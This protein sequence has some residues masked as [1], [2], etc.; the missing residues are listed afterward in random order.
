MISFLCRIDNF[1]SSQVRSRSVSGLS[2]EAISCQESLHI[3]AFQFWASNLFGT[4]GESNSIS[5]L[6][7][8][9]LKQCVQFAYNEMSYLLVRILQ[10]FNCFNLDWSLQSEESKSLGLTY[11]ETKPGQLR[12]TPNFPSSVMGITVCFLPTSLISYTES[13]LQSGL[14]MKMNQV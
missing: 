1:L 11:M 13:L 7:P 6:L 8:E 14:W 3:P 12:L 10:N 4:A 9:S 5:F 2:A